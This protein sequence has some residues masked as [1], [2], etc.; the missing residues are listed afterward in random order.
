MER[1]INARYHEHWSHLGGGKGLKTLRAVIAGA[2]DIN[3]RARGKVPVPS[4][5]VRHPTGPSRI[6][7]SVFLGDTQAS[8][9]RIAMLTRAPEAILRGAYAC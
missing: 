3:P 8:R 6:P 9:H 2:T 5:E 7:S 1:E 4:P